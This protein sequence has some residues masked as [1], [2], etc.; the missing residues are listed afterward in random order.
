MTPDTAAARRLATPYQLFALVLTVG[1]GDRY[2]ITSE[3]RLVA[4]FLMASGVGVF[5]VLSGLAASW[6]LSPAAKEAD[7]DIVELKTMIARLEQ[8]AAF[9][10]PQRPLGGTD[11]SA[12]A[13]GEFADRLARGDDTVEFRRHRFDLPDGLGP[14]PAAA[15]HRQPA[16]RAGHSQHITT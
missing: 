15:C 2:P 4:V 8:T 11:V 1:Y 10:P 5:G 14:G 9:R 3:G 13:G 12:I 6:F 16:D 7:A